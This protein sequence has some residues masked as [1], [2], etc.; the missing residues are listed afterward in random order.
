MRAA[1]ESGSA[2]GNSWRGSVRNGRIFRTFQVPDSILHN[3]SSQTMINQ[4]PRSKSN[5][6]T[7]LESAGSSSHS[8]LGADGHMSTVRLMHLRRAIY[9]PGPNSSDESML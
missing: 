8:R 6:E 1:F 3:S 7:Q 9:L 2:K 4:E 5:A